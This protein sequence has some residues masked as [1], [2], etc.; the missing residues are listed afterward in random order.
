MYIEKVYVH[1]KSS[2]HE[3]WGQ[4]QKCCVYNFVQYIITGLHSNMIWIISLAKMMQVMNAIKC[5]GFN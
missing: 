2:A 5:N 3:R 1:E 4:K